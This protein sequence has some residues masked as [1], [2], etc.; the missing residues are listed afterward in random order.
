MIK[1]CIGIELG[2]TY[3]RAVQVSREDEKFRI[4]K[5]FN[6]PTRRSTDS[7]PDILHSLVNRFGFDRRADVAVAM[8]S[9]AVFFKHIDTDSATLKQIRAGDLAAFEH[10]F[11]IQPDEIVTELCSYRQLP[12]EKWSVLATAINRTSLRET[13]QIL[14]QAKIRPSLV[15]ASIFALCTVVAVNHPEFAA[16]QAIIAYITDSH[17]T[18]AVTQDS[19]VLLVRN[20]PLCVSDDSGNS[21][22]E[23]IAAVLSREAQMTW[24]RVFGAEMGQQAVIYLVAD[25]V[26]DYLRALVEEN[27]HCRTTVVNPYAKVETV[28]GQKAEFPI[29]V[30]EGLA[31]RLLAPHQ[32]K[33]IDFLKAKSI[34]AMPKLNLK[35]ELAACAALVGAIAAFWVISIFVQ[36][37]FL[38]KSYGSIKNQIRDVFKTALPEER[39][40]VNPLFQLEQKLESFRKDYQ[41]FAFFDPAASG[42]LEIL[43]TV[44]AGV[45]TQAGLK[46]DDVLITADSVRINGV[47]DSFESVYQWQRLLQESPGFKLVDVR[48]VQKDPKGQTVRFTMVLSCAP[49]FTEVEQK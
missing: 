19:N 9:D 4:E 13:L 7:P 42:P 6:A 10:S 18:L 15:D 49:S 31:L 11:P 8:S 22:L 41:L 26:G 40:I 47:C 20:I 37:S 43:R 30:A 38:E 48:D 39:N 33:G 12:D 24:R 27:L 35:R 28:S 44:S 3:I 36:L 5:V 23:E 17:L 29:Y 2:P 32:A 45:P 1:R 46:V 16:G 34:Q 21:T 25:A 14:S